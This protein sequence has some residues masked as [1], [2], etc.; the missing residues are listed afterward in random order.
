VDGASKVLTKTSKHK[1][2]SSN[3][4]NTTKIPEIARALTSSLAANRLKILSAGMAIA[5]LAVASPVQAQ[6]TEIAIGSQANTDLDTYSPS[7]GVYPAGGGV[8]TVA[9][10]PFATALLDNTPGTFGIVQ[11]PTG[12]VLSS[13]A[14]GPYN[15]TFSVP[16]GTQAQALYCLMDSVWGSDGD[17]VGTVTVTGT[18]G[19][20]AV[21]TL[22]EGVNIRDCHNDGFANSISDPT[23]VSTYFANGT[24]TQ[25][26]DA[27]MRLDRQE[28]LLPGTFN[29]DTI[30]SIDF[31]GNA[32]GMDGGD[33]FI[34]GMTLAA[35]PEPSTWALLAAGIGALVIYRVRRRVLA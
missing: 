24:T 18:G 30:A 13:G 4:K 25:S 9:G 15:F 12:G 14:S 8:L 22:T 1:I 28:L 33:P 19:E 2:I 27:V 23:V 5:A 29:G 17:T 31:Q 10:V 20:T 6:Y 11:S 7:P 32:L 21:L 34:A 26:T 16:K 35:V 3:M